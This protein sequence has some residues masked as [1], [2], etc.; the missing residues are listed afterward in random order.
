MRKPWTKRE[1]ARLIQLYPHTP[2][3]EIARR[4]GRTEPSIA[5]RAAKLGLKKAPGAAWGRFTKGFTPWNAGLKNVNGVSPTRFKK[6]NKPHTWRPVGSER[7][8]D[9]GYLVRKVSDTGV[10]RV[11][12]RLVHVM[13]WEQ[14]NGPVPAGKIVVFKDR[15]QRN[16]TIENLEC[17]TRAENMKRNSHY[18]RYPPEI[19]EL[20]QLRG[21]LN[22]QINKRSGN[23]RRG[24]TEKHAV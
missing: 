22:R 6:G 8:N 14:H 9:D 23:E 12:W 3:Q 15:D 21:A 17:I 24:R 5:M 1:D 4:M 2:T 11:D 19:S 20:I 10:K 7:I 13:L 16:I 18:N